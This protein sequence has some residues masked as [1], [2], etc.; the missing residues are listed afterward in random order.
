METDSSTGLPAAAEPSGEAA[1]GPPT[2]AASS[3][4]SPTGRSSHDRRGHGSHDT[5][6]TRRVAGAVE[7]AVET[8][9]DTVVDGT[10]D[11]VGGAVGIARAA[12]RRWDERPGARVRRVRRA[13][14]DP[15][16]SLWQLHPEA[17]R[18]SPREVGL[19][20]I[21]VDLV[22]GTAVRGPNQRGGDFLPL[23]QFRSRNWQ[24]RWARLR[25]ALDSLAILP[26]IDVVRYAD[27]YW[28]LDGHNRV[29]AALYG[30]QVGIDANVVEL[31]RPGESA[32]ERPTSMAAVYTGSRAL[33]TAGEGRPVGAMQDEDRIDR[34]TFADSSP[35]GPGAKNLLPERPDPPGERGDDGPDR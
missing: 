21:D 5:S 23:R 7:D 19:K 28:V 6:A 10:S 15:L 2:D 9:V 24:G 4:P 11:L 20:T 31:V 34:P 25:S 14:R 3:R 13:G 8:V 22:A 16:A 27:R 26:P 29:A 1:D 18:A 30:G 33:R 35:A 12:A 17:H 32:K